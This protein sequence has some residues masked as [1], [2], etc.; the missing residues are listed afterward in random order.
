MNM[1]EA[2]VIRMPV[3]ALR[4]LVVFPDMRLHFEVGRSKSVA[5]LKAGMA[6]DQKVFLVAQKNII[7]EDPGKN[8]LFSVGVVVSV[9]QMLKLQ[10][11]DNVR[12]GVEGLYRAR[13][14]ELEENG[15]FLR[16]TVRR[17]RE[18][19]IPPDKAEYAQALVRQTKDAFNEYAELVPQLPP[20]LVLSIIARKEPGEL[21]DYIAGNIIL[22]PFDKQRILEMVNPLKRL[23][24]LCVLLEKESRLLE[25]ENGIRENVQQQIDRNQREYY[26]RQQLKAITDELKEGTDQEGDPEGF[27][28]KIEKA[29]LGE[30]EKKKLL[31]ECDRLERLSPQ[32]PE[33]SVVRTY[34]ETCLS[35]PWNKF[36]KDKL[37]L[38]KAEKILNEDHYGLE[39]VKQR[40]LEL[41]AVRSLAPEIKGQIICLAG[42]PGVG[43]TSVAKSIARAMGRKYVRISLS[44]IHDE[45]EIRGHRKTYIGSM[46][47]RIIAAMQQA[48][49]SNPL[50]LLDEVD[51]LSR[52]YNGDPSSALLE[53]LDPEQ[54]FSFRDH[55]IE[56]PFDLSKV[57]FITTANRSENIPEPL[58]DRMEVIELGS[59]THQEKFFI[60]K[61]HLIPK[62][63]K[64]HGLRASQVKISDDAL[65]LIIDGYTREAGVRKLEQQIAALLRK[66]AVKITNGESRVSYPAG[67]LENALGPVKYKI[68]KPELLPEPGIV[69]GLAWTNAGGEMLQTEVCVLEGSGKLEL[70]GSLGEVMKESARA[71]VSFVRSRAKQLKIDREFY[72]T[73]DI[74]IHFPEGAVPKD[75]PSAGITIAIALVS[76]LTGVPARS[77]TAMT[78][79]ITLRGRVLPIGGLKEKTMA[80]YRMGIKTVIIPAENVPDIKEI[81]AAVTGALEFVP[82][83]SVD[84]AFPRVFG[85]DVIDACPAEKTPPPMQDAFTGKGAENII[86]Q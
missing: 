79:E 29:G 5:A 85:A 15:P 52:D 33:Y 20:E 55:Y 45:A 51:K 84:E 6:D 70:T 75:G 80:A 10:G 21:A 32:S 42:P 11:G 82:V 38:K 64:R 47:G 68:E 35:L 61:R 50:M 62:Q 73:K 19:K 76:A 63:L 16:A 58:L 67:E 1:E 41:L 22:D 57:L 48:G 26:L 65:H 72:K 44:G 81:D 69:N 40:I 49:V 36:S 59:Y 7:D 46:P 28:D 37:D 3:V 71:A 30:E 78:G 34:L 53:V 66:A 4:G 27:R 8:D 9:K 39:K 83:S 24:Q 56:I 86:A 74:H 60:A 77:D 2:L 12:V 18:P 13:L 23:E 25:L 31:R 17:C 14:L 43:K 54:N